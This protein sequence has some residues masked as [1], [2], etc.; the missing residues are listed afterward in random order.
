MPSPSSSLATLRPDLSESFEEFDLEMQ[1]AGYIASRVFPVVE[2][3]SQSGVFGKIPIEQLLQNREVRRAP[4][5]GYSRGQWKFT[6]DS[7]ACQ[8]YGAEEPVDDREA[9]MY[10]N[11]FD[12]ELI[13]ARRAFDVVM[14]N[15]EQRVAS[16]LFSTSTFSGKTSAVGTKWSTHASATPLDDV[17]T[18]VNA[19]WSNSGLWPNALVI[20][21][22][23]FRHLRN[24]AQIIDRV[25]YQGFVDVRAG[26]ITEAALAQA[27]D[28]DEII[29]ANAVKNTAN[30]G[31]SASLASIW[32]D[33]YALVCR[34]ARTNDF[35]EPCLGRTFHWAGDG[36]SPNGVIE[37]Y[38]EESIRSDVIRVRHDVDEKLLYVEA[39]YLL[40]N[41][42]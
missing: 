26:A 16:L 13:A 15:A 25:K 20:S 42:T 17:E 6:T 19:V 37:S 36:S 30:E 4:G 1:R 8:E 7:F 41:I 29:V 31:Q 18:A 21:R 12:A 24:C 28:L 27:F 11:Y 2:V 10:A 35:R 23:V 3:A 40:S 14:R 34:V 38:R 39:G 22:K 5:A 33:S 9:A 32:S